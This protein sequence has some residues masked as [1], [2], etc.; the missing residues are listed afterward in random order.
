[1]KMRK[2]IQGLPIGIWISAG[3]FIALYSKFIQARSDSEMGLFFWTGVGFVLIGLFKLTMKKVIKRET[4]SVQKE[5]ESYKEQLEKQRA[6]WRQQQ[7]TQQQQ[8][9]QHNLIRC[10]SCTANNYSHATVCWRCG[11]RLQ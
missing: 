8:T 1:M 9:A 2:G 11:V 7:H 10:P 6:Q 5:Q 3:I 4:R